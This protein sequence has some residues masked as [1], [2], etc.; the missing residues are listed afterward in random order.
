MA[1]EPIIFNGREF[2]KNKEVALKIKVWDLA[3]H[4]IKPKLVSILVG[5]DPSSKLY[6]QLK[7]KKARQL[8]CEMEIYEIG[9]RRDIGYIVNLIRFLNSKED[10]HGIMV[11][12]PLPKRL[13]GFTS[14]VVKAID[15]K[16]DVDGL[17]PDSLY[18]HPTSKAV[19]EII[20]EARKVTW[21]KPIIRIRARK[22]D[23]VVCV[24]GASGMVGR[25]LVKKLKELGYPVLEADKNTKNLKEISQKAKILV[26]ATGVPGLIK[27]NFGMKRQI[28]VIDVGS[29][30]GDVDFDKIIK[31]SKFITPVPGGVGPVTITCLIENLLEA[32]YNMLNTQSYQN[33]S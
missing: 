22:I 23:D 14:E 26:S 16:K 9:L 27:K 28:I 6:T 4:G 5:D 2:A 11:Q 18:L 13:A 24:I 12:L 32:A 1:L 31:K 33:S 29:P 17:R 25:P 10:V 30:K 19:V 15:P 8:G 3:W 7:E 21:K 20:E